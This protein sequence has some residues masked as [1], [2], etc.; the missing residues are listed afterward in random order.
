M[1]MARPC[2]S[3][4]SG[5]T[6]C[7]TLHCMPRAVVLVRSSAGIP[8][9]ALT[10]ARLP[11]ARPGFRKGE[12][13]E[14]PSTVGHFWGLVEHP[15]FPLF[16]FSLDLRFDGLQQVPWGLIH[17]RRPS[18]RVG[19]LASWRVGEL[20]SWRV[21]ELASWRVGELAG[22]LVCRLGY[23]STWPRKCFFVFSRGRGASIS[24]IHTEPDLAVFSMRQTVAIQGFD[25][26]VFV[27]LLE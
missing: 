21:G 17:G 24:T 14:Q 2:V 1:E 19:E 15:P 22:A 18:W 20:A 7:S 4:L 25:R 6:V 10:I 13:T 26:M 8:Y 9:L 16:W 23:S 5:L 12:E 3:T 11:I 27:P